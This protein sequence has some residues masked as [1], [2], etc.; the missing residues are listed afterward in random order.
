MQLYF[1]SYSI[2]DD[3]GPTMTLLVIL[4]KDQ[5]DQYYNFDTPSILK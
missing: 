2:L 1:A 5:H 4:T 3:I